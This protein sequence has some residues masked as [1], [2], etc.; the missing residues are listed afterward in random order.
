MERTCPKCN[1]DAMQNRLMLIQACTVRTRG[2]TSFGGSG[3]AGGEFVRVSGGG[4]FSG[5]S[6]S[7]L[8]K[9]LAGER[10]AELDALALP[11]IIDFMKNRRVGNVD[12]EIAG[13]RYLSE[14]RLGCHFARREGGPELGPTVEQAQQGIT[15]FFRNILSLLRALPWLPSRL[16]AFF[17]PPPATPAGTPGFPKSWQ[18]F[19]QLIEEHR[20]ARRELHE[21]LA[22]EIGRVDETRGVC[23]RCGARS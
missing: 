17:G 23:M 20:A 21:L 3:W 8:A 2:S 4:H 12:L 5:V 18:Q 9:T 10:H 13:D 7:E 19:G 14:I 22:R 1:A 6:E 11:I 16:R 15:E